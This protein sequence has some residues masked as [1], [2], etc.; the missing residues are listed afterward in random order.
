MNHPSNRPSASFDHPSF[1]LIIRF[2]IVVHFFISLLI[3]FSVI[4]IFAPDAFRFFFSFRYLSHFSVV[5]SLFLIRSVF[6]FR[7][8]SRNSWS[9]SLFAIYFVLRFTFRPSC[10]FSH[11]YLFRSSCSI[12]CSIFFITSLISSLILS[13]ATSH[14]Y[15]QPILK[16]L[17]HY[18]LNIPPSGP[19]TTTL[20]AA[21]YL[22]H[23]SANK[24][25]MQPLYQAFNQ[26]R[27]H[28]A[29]QS[30]T[31]PLSHSPANPSVSRLAT[32][33][34]TCTNTQSLTHSYKH[35]PTQ[36][37][38]QVSLVTSQAKTVTFPVCSASQSLTQRFHTVSK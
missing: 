3:S 33:L 22:C 6:S 30:A 25:F 37:F 14:A 7:P 35:Q 26:P 8:S 4:H 28:L 13:F 31:L 34:P 12:S 38:A 27:S 16:L 18:V 36:P 17:I 19:S 1:S 5:I 10:S 2:V 11:R 20:K 9:I 23:H 29:S 24:M 21:N 15:L 32:L